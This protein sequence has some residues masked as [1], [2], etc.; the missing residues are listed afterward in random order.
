M[1]FSASER[2]F[3]GRAA[4]RVDSASAVLLPATSRKYHDVSLVRVPEY[5]SLPV[6]NQRREV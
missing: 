5:G 6:R 4:S 3:I 2:V 1:D